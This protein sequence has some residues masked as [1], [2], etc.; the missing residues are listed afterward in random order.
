[1]QKKAQQSNKSFS[2]EFFHW[3]KIAA[4]E[5]TTLFRFDYEFSMNLAE[6]ILLSIK[7]NNFFPSLG[8][9]IASVMQ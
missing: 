4:Y 9:Y 6:V 5:N 3:R 7:D 2:I 8:I 1:M